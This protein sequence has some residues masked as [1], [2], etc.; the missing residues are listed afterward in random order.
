MSDGARD[1]GVVDP[2][3]FTA[4]VDREGP[5][6]FAYLVRRAPVEAEDLLGRVW[7]EAYA[8]R[9]SFDPARGSARSWLFGVARH[10]LLR[11]WRDR[12]PDLTESMLTPTPVDPWEE[13]DARL[14]S[15]ALVGPLRAAL[16]DLPEVDRE[17]LLLIA[18]EQ[19]TPTEAAAVVGIPPATARTRLHRARSRM[20]TALEA[21][22]RPDAEDEPAP[23]HPAGCLF[24]RPMSGGPR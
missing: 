11:H 15:A 24:A 22:H 10:V 8:S 13:V 9:R 6:V 7:V 4:L 16:V 1:A 19:L 14:D 23:A 21:H 3:A 5:D 20:R 17:M 18:W 12:R 2:V